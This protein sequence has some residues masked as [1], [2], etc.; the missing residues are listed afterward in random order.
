MSKETINALELVLGLARENA[1]DKKMAVDTP[2][3]S[4]QYDRQQAA[5]ASVDGL[6]GALK[7]G[8]GT[9]FGDMAKDMKISELKGAL[10][11]SES[12]R[13]R[14]LEALRVFLEEDEDLEGA[15][16]YIRGQDA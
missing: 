8:E 14:D 3:L 5:L 6:I 4:E 16:A 7:T 10:N 13:S 11:M 9:P 15:L 1:I 2:D 12:L